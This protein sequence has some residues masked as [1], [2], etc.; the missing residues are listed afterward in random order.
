MIVKSWWMIFGN[1]TF[2]TKK[3]VN[4][5]FAKNNLEALILKSGWMTD[6]N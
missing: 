5:G 4:P 6:L 1:L 3:H 2:L